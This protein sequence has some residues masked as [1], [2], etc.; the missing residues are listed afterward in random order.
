[1]DKHKSTTKPS[2]LQ[3]KKSQSIDW[4]SIAEPVA[5]RLLREPNHKL[6]N[7]DSLRWGNKGSKKLDLRTGC[8]KDFETG[9]G[10][11]VFWILSNP[12][13]VMIR[14]KHLPGCRIKV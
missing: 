2:P 3:E 13:W 6:S 10:G 7:K 1:M 4:A 11:G 5:L 8:W 14:L 9:Q 12:N